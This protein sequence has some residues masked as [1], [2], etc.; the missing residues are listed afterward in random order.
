[1]KQ[2]SFDVRNQGSLDHTPIESYRELG[3]KKVSGTI[4]FVVYYAG[5][6]T[7]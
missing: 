3:R 4:V 5:Q 7:Q 1:M 2:W 6:S